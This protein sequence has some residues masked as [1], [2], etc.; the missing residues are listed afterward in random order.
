MD[1]SDLP[2]GFKPASA[3]AYDRASA[4]LCERTLVTLLRGLG[5]W[6]SSIVLVGGL[7]PRYLIDRERVFMQETAH[8]GT[9]D[10]DLVL[11]IELLVQIDAYESIERN[12][13]RMGFARDE[14]TGHGFRAMARTLLAERLGMDEAA[15]EAQLA[16]GVRDTL[17]RAYNRTQ[18]LEQRRQM[19][20][21][22]AD[23]L[24]KLREVTAFKG[25]QAEKG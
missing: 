6:K 10:I 25:Q 3:S 18:F 1:T 7:A 20:Q 24:D 22:W 4:D 23:Y 14:M 17:G 15:I 11:A 8:I 19:M 9:L 5:P 12:L 13:K 21:T 2:D 16:H